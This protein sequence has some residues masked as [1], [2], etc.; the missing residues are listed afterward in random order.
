M[1]ISLLFV[2]IIEG[3]KMTDINRRLQHNSVNQKQAKQAAEYLE[4]D[5]QGKEIEERGQV[6]KGRP[7][8]YGVAG[9]LPYKKGRRCFVENL[10]KKR[11]NKTGDN[12]ERGTK[13]LFCGR[14]QKIFFPLRGTEIS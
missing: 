9:G 14:G 5:R 6:S 4:L 13:I 3:R 11:K 12:R 7:T 1:L 2:S 8:P 10:K